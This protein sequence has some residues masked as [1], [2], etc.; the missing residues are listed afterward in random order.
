M[1]TA[2]KAGNKT[3]L[4]TGGAGFIGSHVADAYLAHGWSVTVV[5]NLSSGR[6]E[7]IPDGVDFVELDVRDPQ[8]HELF[9]RK[10]G[11][12]LINHHAAQVDVRL[13]VRR[14]EFDADVNVLGL[15]NLLEAAREELGNRTRVRLDVGTGEVLAHVALLDRDALQPGDTALAQL[16]LEAPT[17]ALPGDRFVVRSMTPVLTI[18][19]GT[20]VD[21]HPERHKRFDED[22]LEALEQLESGQ[23]E[24]VEQVFAQER[25]TPQSVA[26]VAVRLGEAEE[27]VEQAV[28]ELLAAG[29][30]APMGGTPE[31]YLHADGLSSARCFNSASP[32]ACR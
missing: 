30:L 2:R 31:R 23:T 24:A 7:N 14:P 9:D 20:V 15:L 4:V 3:A 26:E 21:A 22:A 12:E 10:G 16:V 5:D 17:V 1:G 8:L 19:G 6:R 29:R 18:G 13:S 11:F 25:F 27:T 28:G 32:S